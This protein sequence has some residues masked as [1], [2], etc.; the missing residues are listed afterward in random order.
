M[1][2]MN[3]DPFWTFGEKVVDVTSKIRIN[4]MYFLEV[5]IQGTLKTTTNEALI[6]ITNF[7][8]SPNVEENSAKPLQFGW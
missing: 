3:G 2:I 1:Y 7:P 6:V 4:K 8:P 5:A